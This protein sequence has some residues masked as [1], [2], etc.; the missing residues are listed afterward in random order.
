MTDNLTTQQQPNQYP[1]SVPQYMQPEDEISL[2]DLW[3]VIAKHKRIFW[4]VFTTILLLALLAA[5]LIPKKY[6]LTSTIGI[7]LMVQDNKE[8]LLES[9]E[10][11]KAKLDNALVP[12]ILSQYE[13][14]DIRRTRFNISVP[15]N[16]DLVIIKTEVK[17]GEIEKFSKILSVMT[18]EIENN[19][20]IIL[21]PIR[22]GI[23]AEII[24]KELELKKAN[25]PRFYEPIK[26]NI[27]SDLKEAEVELKKFEDPTLYGYKLEAL[28]KELSNEKANLESLKDNES[29][30]KNKISRLT[31]LSESIE[32][33][34]SQVKQQINDTMTRRNDIAVNALSSTYDT[35]IIML[36]NELQQYRD[37]L[38]S[39]EER[40]Y[41]DIENEFSEL[42]K[43]LNENGRMQK[44]QQTLII[45]KQR[46]IEN[47]KIEN[48]LEIEKQQ[49][50]IARINA[51]LLEKTA[52]WEQNIEILK[53]EMA[54]LNQ[55]LDNIIDTRAISEPMRSEM[56]TGTSKK[57]VV[58]LGGVLAIMF[59]LFATFLA[60]FARKVSEKR[61]MNDQLT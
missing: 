50:V 34:I 38:V 54:D 51:E 46:E 42:L 11:V 31:D 25:D 37:R 59:G 33:E 19:H 24:Q 44:Q 52:D 48:K 8:K 36:D 60:E 47:F 10:T 9:P 23:K 6:T 18:D 53:K 28:N 61:E 17:E 7:G 3:L 5:L 30:L 55:Q 49:A 43:E 12:K 29:L 58:L 35:P 45:E 2:V 4:Y 26:K 15:K 14:K 56:P 22:D 21:K 27:E 13:D 40:L 16:S 32:D 57:V 41:I 20:K 1:L 39:L